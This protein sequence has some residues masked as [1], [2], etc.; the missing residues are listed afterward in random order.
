MIGIVLNRR[1]VARVLDDLNLTRERRS[2]RSY[3]PCAYQMADF[4]LQAQC[5]QTS[6]F[7]FVD[8]VSTTRRGRKRGERIRVKSFFVRGAR[9]SSIGVL[10]WD[11]LLAHDL[12]TGSYTADSFYDFARRVLVPIMRPWPEPC[13]ILVLDNCNIHRGTRLKELLLGM[14]CGILHTP[15]YCPWFSP[16]EEAFAQLKQ[17]LRQECTEGDDVVASVHEAYSRITP[18]NCRAYI[19]HTGYDPGDS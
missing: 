17:Y 10:H 15:P 1:R 7:L 18:A 4:I 6:Q 3:Q 19:L 12:R 8:E 16:T 9:Y 13:S 11:G 5:Y 14:G 2:R